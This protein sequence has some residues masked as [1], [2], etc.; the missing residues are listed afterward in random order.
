MSFNYCENRFRISLLCPIRL[1]SQL[2]DL[3]VTKMKMRS[4]IRAFTRLQAIGYDRNCPL[5]WWLEQTVSCLLRMNQKRPGLKPQSTIP[6][7]NPPQKLVTVQITTGDSSPSPSHTIWFGH[8][9]GP[10]KIVPSP[11]EQGDPIPSLFPPLWWYNSLY[12]TFE[13][14]SHMARP[15]CLNVCHWCDPS[16]V[17]AVLVLFRRCTGLYIFCMSNN[18]QHW[19]SCRLSVAWYGMSH[20]FV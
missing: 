4:K 1:S 8:Q 6:M 14:V 20:P 17:H 12:H 16:V 11:Y 3:Q 5:K 10:C 9:I 13:N 7:Y 19:Q 18:T 15:L 2:I